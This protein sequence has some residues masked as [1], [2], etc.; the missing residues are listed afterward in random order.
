MK[1]N[2]G[3]IKIII[4]YI[5]GIFIIPRIVALALDFFASFDDGDS[6]LVINITTYGIL[7]AILLI[8]KH[9]KIS[10]YFRSFSQNILRNLGIISLLLVVMYVILYQNN[11]ILRFFYNSPPSIN[12]Q[13]LDVIK[14]GYPIWYVIIAVILVPFVEEV[15]FRDALY[16]IARKRYGVV[17]GVIFSSI[18]FGLMHTLSGDYV[19]LPLYSILG[20]A[21]MIGYLSTKNLLVPIITHS[22]YNA[23]SIFIL[24]G[25]I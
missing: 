25:V 14:V 20:A 22:L 1:V 8:M 9:K 16:K 4:S 2:N 23:I 6:K 10:G 12:Q 19:Y 18:L 5:F 3:N 17:A 13:N 7:F 15:V 11:A 21:L 24:I